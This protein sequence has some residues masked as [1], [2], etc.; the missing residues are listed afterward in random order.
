MAWDFTFLRSQKTYSL[1]ATLPP[2]STSVPTCSPK[3]HPSRFPT[4]AV[5]SFLKPLPARF[6]P[7][8]PSSVPH[9]TRHLHASRYFTFPV[10]IARCDYVHALY[11][12]ERWTHAQLRNPFASA[13]DRASLPRP[14]RPSGCVSISRQPPQLPSGRAG[15][16]LP[17]NLASSV[18]CCILE[19]TAG[20]RTGRPVASNHRTNTTPTT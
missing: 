8:R 14:A 16:S 6:A 10:L 5:R 17:F 19:N 1:P 13:I 7:R 2:D 18:I 11:R 4:G 20:C 9:P 15:S 12:R 3:R